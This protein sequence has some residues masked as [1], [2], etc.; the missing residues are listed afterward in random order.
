MSITTS[1]IKLTAEFFFLR[2][3]SETSSTN[4][5]YSGSGIAVLQLGKTY[6]DFTYHLY[7]QHATGEIRDL[8]F[9]SYQYVSAADT[10]IGLP[11]DV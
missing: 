9:S 7:Y 3:K 6:M 1:R 4:G 10:T 5:A 2:P 8:E 11:V